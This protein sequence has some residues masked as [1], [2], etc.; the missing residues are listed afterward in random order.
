MQ[1]P[2]IQ[3]PRPATAEHAPTRQTSPEGSSRLRTVTG[4]RFPRKCSCGCGQPIPRDLDIRYVVDFGAP[5][6]YPAYLREHSP[7]F[8]TYRGGRSRATKQ[9]LDAVPGFTPASDLI[10]RQDRERAAKGGS[11][12]ADRAHSEAD[13]TAT[14]E[15][16]RPWAS[17]QLVFNAGSFES[18]RS[19]FA[20][21]AKDGET[22]EKLRARLN[23]VILEDLEQKVLAL[24]A[25]H[26]KLRDLD[27]GESFGDVVARGRP[28]PRGECGD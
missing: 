6:P 3:H 7:D 1:Q 5:R 13:A 10:A 18:A 12:T 20:D 14:P 4:N 24:R 28:R 23:R 9:A 11:P 22:A 17:G 8:G 19:A 25:L 21:Y 15:S 2:S 27:G 16:G 26:T